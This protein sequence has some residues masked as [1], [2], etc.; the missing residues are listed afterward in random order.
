MVDT[1]TTLQEKGFV[2]LYALLDA[3][4]CEELYGIIRKRLSL[5]S[6][7]HGCKNEDEYFSVINRWPLTSVLDTQSVSAIINS[8]RTKIEVILQEKES[9][10]AFEI[11]VLY[12]S[13]VAALATPVHQDISYVWQKPYAFSTWIGLTEVKMKDSPLQFLPNSHRDTIRPAVDFW[14][15]DFIDNIRLSSR[16]QQASMT[17][18]TSPGDGFL[19]SSRILHASQAHYSEQ[20][21]L[22]IVIRWGNKSS[23]KTAVPPPLKVP[24][25]M[26]NCGKIT[27]ELLLKSLKKI[28]T[29]D[30]SDMRTAISQWLNKLEKHSLPFSCNDKL[31]IEALKKLKILNDACQT[32]RG[33]DSQGIVYPQLWHA[34]LLP[35]KKLAYKKNNFICQ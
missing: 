18:P 5:L 14:Q 8:I 12:K 15:P 29:Y 30:A 3:K 19:F 26:W 7:T 20:E 28:Y 34:F 1:L 27:E 9:F 33:G 16:W 35:L 32:Y 25:G 10:E 6:Q 31:A 13:K 21:R 23:L 22:A 17:I 24:F 11:D 4:F 2:Q